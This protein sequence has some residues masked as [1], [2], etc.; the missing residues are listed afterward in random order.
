M[1][2]LNKNAIYREM[3]TKHG[4][5]NTYLKISMALAG[6]SDTLTKEEAKQLIAIIDAG[7]KEVKNKI[8]D[9]IIK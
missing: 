9:S 4:K 2:I 8:T 3:L 7:V 5:N 6:D 1:E